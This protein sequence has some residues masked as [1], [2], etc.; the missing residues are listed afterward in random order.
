VISTVHK[1]E[2]R[3][4]GAAL[5]AAFACTG[6]L[7]ADGAGL[8]CNEYPV[9]SRQAL[10]CVA[11]S[12]GFGAKDAVAIGAAI[13]AL[14]ISGLSFWYSLYKDKVARRQSIEDD[15]WIRKVLGPILIE[16]LMRDVLA[17]IAA[18]P[19]DCSNAGTSPDQ[20]EEFHK[21]YQPKL[22]QLAAAMHSLALLDVPLCKLC[23]D[24]LDSI[25]DTMAEYCIRNSMK[26]RDGEGRPTNT[27]AVAS[28]EVR[29]QLHL[30]LSEI[31]RYQ[32]TR[33]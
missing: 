17:L 22:Q 28:T 32:T 12:S 20:Y 8:V 24:K 30:I 27:Q 9:G 10:V 14:I 21:Q 31:K 11:P 26:S 7:G 15:F 19:S 29:T 23:L 1:H 2:C 18:F 13:I 3:L 33:V 16:P 6:S 25:E 5:L 4:F